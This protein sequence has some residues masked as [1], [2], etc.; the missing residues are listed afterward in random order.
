[1]LKSEDY[2]DFLNL[3]DTDDTISPQ[4]SLNQLYKLVKSE[5]DNENEEMCWDEVSEWM[6]STS[7]GSTSKRLKENGKLHTFL[8]P[9]TG[10]LLQ[11]WVI[12]PIKSLDDVVL[13][14]PVQNKIREATK[15]RRDLIEKYHNRHY[16]FENI[17]QCYDA[18][19]DELKTSPSIRRH[20]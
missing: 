20:F 17:N 6:R 3:K 13:S 1:M 9:S 11:E 4:S 10:Q 15:K 19:Y 18:M 5:S 8:V 2:S 7:M 14:M 12:S 16:W